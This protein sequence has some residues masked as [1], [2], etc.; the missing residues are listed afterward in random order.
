MPYFLQIAFI[1]VFCSLHFF[2]FYSTFVQ[3]KSV[4]IVF[5]VMIMMIIII[6][7][8][9]IIIIINKQAPLVISVI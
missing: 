7:I 6:T 2:G 1:S 4:I 3:I 5:A 8:I 9:I